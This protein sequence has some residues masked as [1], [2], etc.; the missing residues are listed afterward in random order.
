MLLQRFD[1]LFV[2]LIMMQIL[3][4]ISPITDTNILIKSSHP[5]AL[6]FEAKVSFHSARAV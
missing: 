5:M 6:N 1:M 2:D 3:A 4:N